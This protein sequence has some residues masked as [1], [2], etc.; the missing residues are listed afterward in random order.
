MAQSQLTTE[1]TEYIYGSILINCTNLRDTINTE[2][3]Q[4]IAIYGKAMQ[5]CYVQYTAHF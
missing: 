3:K 5:V 1:K 2:I 4:W